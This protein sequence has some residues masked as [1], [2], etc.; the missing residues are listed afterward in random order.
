M[1]KVTVLLHLLFLLI[2]PSSVFGQSTKDAVL[3]LKK[4]QV[5]VETGI[6]YRDYASAVADAKFPVKLFLESSESKNDVG[7]SS[8]LQKAIEHYE[9]A[10]SVWNVKFSC[11]RGVTDYMHPGC[12]SDIFYK[13]KRDYPSVPIQTFWGQESLVIDGAVLIIWNKAKEEVQI[14][15]DL[16]S[17]VELRAQSVKAEN[18]DLRKENGALRK[19]LETL[20]MKVADLQH[21]NEKARKENEALTSENANLKAEID[22]LKNKAASTKRKNRRYE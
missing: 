7:L 20:N 3:A 17:K 19:E 14:A 1:K 9:F 22:S 5:K 21:E 12:D 10:N 6:S 13:I 8:S 2:V 15:S 18:E 11:G 4:L 16:L